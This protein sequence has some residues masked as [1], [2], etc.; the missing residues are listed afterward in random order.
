MFSG[1]VL[2]TRMK[3]ARLLLENTDLTIEAIAEMLGYRDAGNFYRAF[4]SCFHTTPRD[5]PKRRAQL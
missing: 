4:R 2:E 3:K 5:Y 1:L